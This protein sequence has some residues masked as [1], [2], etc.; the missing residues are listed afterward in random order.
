M[1]N[2]EGLNKQ[3]NKDIIKDFPT[4]TPA[5]SSSEHLSIKDRIEEYSNVRMTSGRINE[6]HKRETYLVDTDV[7]AKLSDLVDYFEATNGLDS[8][9][10]EGKTLKQVRD[11]R[12]LAKGI[13]SKLINFAIEQVLTS[14]EQ[15]EGI[16]PN[17]ERVRHKAS[18]GTY[19]RTFKFTENGTTYL[20]TQN[21][22]GHEIEFITSDDTSED[23]INELF[24]TYVERANK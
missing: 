22:R 11:D 21:N 17:V 12:L 23:E 2:K 5:P 7:S 18:D 1:L 4:D 9:Y 16:I 14:W 15:S 24:Q 6:T 19:H 10:K 3:G 13:K 8:R 20:L